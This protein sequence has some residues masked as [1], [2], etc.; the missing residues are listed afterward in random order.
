VADFC[1]VTSPLSNVLHWAHLACII[2]EI[3][4][5]F[6]IYIFGFMFEIVSV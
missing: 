5:H 1:V 4:R 3:P 2:R 6:R